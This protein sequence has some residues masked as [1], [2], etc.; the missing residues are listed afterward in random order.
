MTAAQQQPDSGAAGVA[1]LGGVAVSAGLGWLA[2][3]YLDL[4]AVLAFFV[5]NTVSFVLG[6]CMAAARQ[7]DDRL[8]GWDEEPVPYLVA[9]RR[10]THTRRHA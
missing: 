10:D 3:V 7:A 1:F 9:A 4:A 8:Y 2:Y 5:A 6:A